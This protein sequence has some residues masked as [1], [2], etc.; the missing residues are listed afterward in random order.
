MVTKC[1]WRGSLHFLTPGPHCF[2][3][4]LLLCAPAQGH[5]IGNLLLGS[6]PHPSTQLCKASLV[7]PLSACCGEQVLAAQPPNL[8]QRTPKG[9]AQPLNPAETLLHFLTLY[10]KS[11]D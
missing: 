5:V 9:A 3:S 11:L 2:L 1:C 7:A 10:E 6:V 8:L 4:L